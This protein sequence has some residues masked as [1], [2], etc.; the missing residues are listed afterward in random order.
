[1]EPWVVEA[2]EYLNHPLRAGTSEKY[3]LPSLEL[4]EEIQQTGD[5]FFP[6]QFISAVLGG[7]QSEE[8]AEIVRQFLRTH[9]TFPY[10]LRNKTLMAADMLF[11]VEKYSQK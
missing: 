11:R 4:L 1:M 6:R 9:P 3:I 5:I 8:A 7:H 2:A 10:R